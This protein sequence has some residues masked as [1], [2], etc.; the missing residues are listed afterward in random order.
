MINFDE[1]P[2]NEEIAAQLENYAR[3]SASREKVIRENRSR[4]MKVR[5]GKTALPLLEVQPRPVRPLV[6]VAFSATGEYLGRI[7][8]DQL[9][10]VPADAKIKWEEA[11]W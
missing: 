2:S 7:T 11:V 4:I 6:P 1:I 9:K 3:I 10:P 5:C 8:R